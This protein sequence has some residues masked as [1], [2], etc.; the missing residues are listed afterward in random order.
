M[1]KGVVL[2][3]GAAMLVTGCGS[4][5][6]METSTRAA[7]SRADT[8]YVLPSAARYRTKGVVFSRLDSVRTE[9]LRAR[10]DSLAVPELARLLPAVVVTRAAADDP[11]ALQRVHVRFEAIAF[12]RTLPRQILSDVTDLALFVPTFGRNLGKPILP[13]SR[14]YLEVVRPGRRPGEFRHEDEVEADDLEQLL[15][16]VRKVLDP[17]YRG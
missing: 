2:F 6:P 12:R 5:R 14:L 10:L 4:V 9:R 11:E 8:V 16:Q 3:A 17:G 7:I 13:S 15:F 1:I